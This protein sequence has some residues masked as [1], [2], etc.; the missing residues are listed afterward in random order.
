MRLQNRA[1]RIGG[2]PAR[3]VHDG[4]NVDELGAD[5]IR[6]AI[7][8]TDDLTKAPLIQ[9]RHDAPGQRTLD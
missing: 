3:E 5:S 7:G 8:W 1:K 2:E 6:D 9:L 4:E